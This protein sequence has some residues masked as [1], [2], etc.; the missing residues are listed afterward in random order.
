MNQPTLLGPLIVQNPESEFL[1]QS[2][3]TSVWLIDRG[4]D[5]NEAQVVMGIVKDRAAGFRRQP[6]T[7]VS[8]KEGDDQLNASD[9]FEQGFRRVRHRLEADNPGSGFRASALDHPD[10]QALVIQPITFLL[11]A[12]HPCSISAFAAKQGLRDLVVLEEG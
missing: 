8:G 9:H 12:D 5:G 1:Q 4:E 3:G 11:E 6:L 10:S 2:V 7:P